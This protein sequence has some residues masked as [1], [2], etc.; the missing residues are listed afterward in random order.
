M[1]FIKLTKGDKVINHLYLTETLTTNMLIELGEKLF[2]TVV[3]DY[4][5]LTTGGIKCIT[6]NMQDFT[7]E[8]NYVQDF[9]LSGQD[10]TIHSLM[11]TL[12][13][14]TLDEILDYL[15]KTH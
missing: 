2:D 12:Q 15:V 4:S 3:I 10:N 11:H 7:I 8:V 1:Y 14:D 9:T 6:Q 13:M 5:S